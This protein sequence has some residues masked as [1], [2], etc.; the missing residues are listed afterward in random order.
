V[1]DMN[2]RVWGWQSL[3]ARAGVDFPHLLWLL[4]SEQPIPQTRARP[5]V[6]WVRLATDTP[7]ALKELVA[8]RLDPRDYLR[9][10][11]AE[12]ESA[13]FAWDDPLPGLCELPVIAYMVCRRRLRRD[14]K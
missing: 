14:G 10:L 4:A 5:G 1:L 8:G 12:H 13:I 9:S 2:P 3:C 7:T 11:G 6:G